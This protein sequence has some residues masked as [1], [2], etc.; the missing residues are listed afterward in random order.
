[1]KISNIC[2]LPKFAIFSLLLFISCRKEKLKCMGNC[3]DITFAG[4]VVNKADNTPIA[5]QQVKATLYH[6]GLCIGCTVYDAGSATTGSDGRF[7]IGTSFDTSQLGEYHFNVSLK[8]PDN[9]IL[10][11]QPTGP[12]ITNDQTNAGE[13]FYEID[14]AKTE[15]LSFEFFPKTVL[16]IR[17]QRSSAIGPDKTLGLD[18]TFDDKTSGWGIIESNTNADTTV[19][20][21]TSANLYTKIRSYRLVSANTY[22]SA[23]DSVLCRSNG[24]NAITISY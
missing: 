3:T 6:S 1:M 16:K 12:E 9:Y 8:A 22:V 2:R 24:N 21:N 5:N 18:F 14:P 23:T 17:L 13:T 15:H 4:R 19:T 7:S 20:I 11:P 10:Y